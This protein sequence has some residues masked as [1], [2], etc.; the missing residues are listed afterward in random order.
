MVLG[1]T[2]MYLYTLKALMDQ[3]AF[4]RSI[5]FEARVMAGPRYK[6]PDPHRWHPEDD[7]YPP[8]YKGWA[9]QKYGEPR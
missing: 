1:E 7:K 8:D 2:T 4:A 9:F 6:I 5:K 3:A